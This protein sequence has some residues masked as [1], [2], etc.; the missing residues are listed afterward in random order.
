MGMIGNTPGW[1]GKTFIV[2]GLG[3]V[4]F[5]SMR[6]LTRAGAKCVGIVEWDGAIWNQDG[7]DPK[8]IEEYKNKAHTIN[9]FPGAEV[10]V[11]FP[12]YTVSL[13]LIKTYFFPGL[14]WREERPHV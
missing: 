2:Q 14:S 7:I 1:G 4:G 10:I 8:A 6:Y 9:G 5:H 13:Y 3:N 11:I 12:L